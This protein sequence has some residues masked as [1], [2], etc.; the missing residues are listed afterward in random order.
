VPAQAKDGVALG[1][2]GGKPVFAL[3]VARHGHRVAGLVEQ[4][5]AEAV[6]V[7]CEA[8]STFLRI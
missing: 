4:D 6:A 5:V 2:R 7:Q 8:R 3:D 1:G